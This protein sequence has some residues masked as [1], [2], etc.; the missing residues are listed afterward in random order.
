MAEKCYII[1]AP[2]DRC[3]TKWVKTYLHEYKNDAFYP[4]HELFV[5]D[6]INKI[7]PAWEP[8]Q[9]EYETIESKKRMMVEKVDKKL[10]WGKYFDGIKKIE[11]DTVVDIN[12]RLRYYLDER[13]DEKILMGIGGIIRDPRKSIRSTYNGEHC[14]KYPENEMLDTRL[15]AFCREWVYYVDKMMN[16][17]DKVWMFEDL[18]DYSVMAADLTAWV[19]LE[20]NKVKWN[21]FCN[22][23]IHATQKWK[24]PPF[25]S[26]TS[27][28]K[29]ILYDVCGKT[30]RKLGYR[31]GWR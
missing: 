16:V 17:C 7:T 15:E 29:D 30:M 4:H 25:E 12:H 19:G 10:F 26:W 6:L 9:D 2:S 14:N 3:G 8:I 31:T 22:E 11:H 23:V 18:L 5:Q 24:F 13:P 27:V 21:A 1:V 20:F 28:Q